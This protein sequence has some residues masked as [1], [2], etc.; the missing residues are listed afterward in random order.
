MR[1]FVVSGVQKIQR[2]KTLRIPEAAEGSGRV[3]TIF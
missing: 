2:L 3:R 1:A